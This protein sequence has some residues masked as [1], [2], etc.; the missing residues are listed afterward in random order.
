MTYPEICRDL[1]DAGI[2]SAE[3]DAQLL[4]GHFCGRDRLAILSDPQQDYDTPALADA[5]RC[6]CAR[7][8]L[9]YLIGVWEFYRQSY[10]VSPHCLIPRSDTEILVEEAIRRLP[11]GAFFA[12]LCAGSGCIGVSVL[13]ERSDTSALAVELSPDALALAKRN[14]VRNGVADRYTA[15]LGD[16]LNPSADWA[17]GVP[18]PMAILSN[19]PYIRTDVLAE[20]SPEVGHEPRMAL[21]GGADGLIFYR[22]LLDLA[23]NRLADGG[24]CL[25]EIGYDQG[26]ALE[27]LALEKGFSCVIKKD[28]GGCDRVAI[29]HPRVIT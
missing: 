11:R 15:V 8:P 22:A 6:R 21:D 7:E 29:L 18:K 17:E 2:E 19:P 4:I 12:D 25:F 10:E 5:V 26:E 13:A 9:Q 14:A 28:F 20:L 16:V 1:R 24:F 3:W 27:E 23:S